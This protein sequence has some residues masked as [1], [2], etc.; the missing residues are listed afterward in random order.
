MNR[1]FL[2]LAATLALQASPAGA[3]V[4][5]R[6]E[7]L[8]ALA[9][10]LAGRGAG[11]RLELELAN[12]EVAVDGAASRVAVELV[13]FDRESRRFVALVAA[14]GEKVRL[15]G[16]AFQVHDVPVPT[17]PVAAG[18]VIAE[19]D[20]EWLP[21]RADRLDR[22][23]ATALAQLVGMTP[24][25][26][27]KAGRAV[28]VSE[29]RPPVLVVKGALVT[30]SVN[31]PG[32]ALTATGRALD[33]GADGDVVRVLNVQSKRTVEG[34]VS[35]QNQVRIHSRQQLAAKE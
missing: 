9:E 28:K 5:G 1:I 19:A 34:L 25:R 11:D 18:E 2:C 17:R 35:G 29:I 12:R 31:A 33:D 22:N 15:S 6:D 21:V 32:L 14:G 10:A 26:G 30:M 3:A 27:L 23:A 7:V 4:Y 24:A 16:R 13:D 20:L 8:A